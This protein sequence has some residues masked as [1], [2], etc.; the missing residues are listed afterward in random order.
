MKTNHFQFSNNCFGNLYFMTQL[1][2]TL[3][4]GTTTTNMGLRDQNA[5]VAVPCRN[6]SMKKL[7]KCAQCDYALPCATTLM[8][9][10][11]T[12]S[13]EKPNKCN[14]CDYA[15]SQAVH[16]RTH[17]KTHSGEK[18]NK[19]NQCDFAS[20]W[21]GNLRTHLKTHIGEKSNKCNQCDYSSASY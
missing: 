12:H 1:E 3:T 8:S 18:S 7:N 5:S 2:R 10:A 21:A 11:R 14:Q 6:R 13:G 16:L 4:H 15:S 9:H 20:S 19:C 17:L